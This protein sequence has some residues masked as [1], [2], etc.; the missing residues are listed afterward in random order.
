MERRVMYTDLDSMG[1]DEEATYVPV[2]ELHLDE[3]QVKEM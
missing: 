2:R 3:Q 1:F